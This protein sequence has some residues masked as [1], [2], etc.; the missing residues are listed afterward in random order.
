MCGTR[1]GEL[2]DES[3]PRISRSYGLVANVHDRARYALALVQTRSGAR[4]QLGVID[5]ELRR[6]QAERQ[7]LLHALGEATYRGDKQA[8]KQTGDRIRALDEEIEQE[9]EKER[10]VVDEASSRI[11]RERGFVAPTQ[12]VTQPGPERKET[13]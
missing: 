8:A 9:R 5:A 4:R 6:L 12:V 3:V 13:E 1:L 10:R 7:R 2:A 11:A